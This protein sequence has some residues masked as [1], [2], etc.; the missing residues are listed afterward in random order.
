[1]K[2]LYLIICTCAAT[3]AQA[4]GARFQALSMEEARREAG[5]QG[6]LL[7]VDCYTSWCGPCKQ[8]TNAEFPKKEAGEF[9]NPRFVCVKFDMEK[10]E[11]REI[12][13]RYAVNIYPT[14]LVLAAD[15]S[16]INRVIG[17]SPMEQF[18]KKIE[19][20]IAPRNDMAT[21]E[22]EFAGGKMSKERTRDF[23]LRLRDAYRD[24]L[25]TVAADDLMQR[26]D[27]REKS[28]ADYWPLFADPRVT[29]V[30]SP[31]FLF[32]LDHLDDFK[33]S[34]GEEAVER[35]L[36]GFRGLDEYLAA[37]AAYKQ[38]NREKRFLLDYAMTLYF[39]REKSREIADELFDALD[40]RERVDTTY[41]PLFHLLAFSEWGMTRFD[42]LLE[43]KEEFYRTRGQQTVDQ[44]IRY[45][46]LH[47]LMM[48]VKGHDKATEQEFDRMTRQV[49]D[50]RL[51]ALAPL[52]TMTRAYARRDAEGLLAACREAF[53]LFDDNLAL[54]IAQ[55]LVL[56]LKE[57]LPAGQ[58]DQLP[59][60]VAD[61]SARLKSD[62]VKTLLARL[63]AS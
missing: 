41:W 52:V 22:A 45:A 11:G 14:F 56:F 43:H 8:M 39:S 27:D 40:D 34:A 7:F 29:P 20:A 58:R 53:P 32:L 18:I 63:V 37:A 59:A 4:Q 54:N 5:Q 19:T 2:L 3:F 25:L 13:A 33:Q 30:S 26:L 6:K 51:P 55:P 35:R 38:G 50:Y 12:A 60:L 9:F 44:S 62:A 28:S 21:L 48:I 42:Y 57:C 23:I 17:A 47:K 24:S 15:G 49:N 61:M 10:G 1:M 31:R 46:F 36:K 16:E